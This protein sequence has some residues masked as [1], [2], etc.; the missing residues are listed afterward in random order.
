MITR[1]NLNKLHE[2]TNKVQETKEMAS[3]NLK[4]AQDRFGHRTH[5]MVREGKEIELT[6]KIMWDEV[7]YIG[8]SCESGQVLR[9][10]HPEV[11]EMYKKQDQAAEELKKFAIVEMG[12]NMQALTLSDYLKATESLFTLML[13]ERNIAQII[14][15]T[16]IA[17]EKIVP[18][19]SKNV[20]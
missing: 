15:A 20:I 16:E 19:G 13:E 6:E 3:E 12:M 18:F 17:N 14:P 4:T 11:F 8:P 5:K 2:L 10:I 1:D 7:F 9:G